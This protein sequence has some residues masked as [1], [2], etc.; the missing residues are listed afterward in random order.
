[1]EGKEKGRKER[2]KRILFFSPRKVA[3]LSPG[4]R[5]KSPRTPVFP[6]E[7]GKEEREKEEEMDGFR[8]RFLRGI[9]GKKDGRKDGKRMERMLFFSLS[10]GLF[11]LQKKEET[12]WYQGK[13]KGKKKEKKDEVLGL[14]DGIFR[15]R[16]EEGRTEEKKEEDLARWCLTRSSVYSFILFFVALS[17]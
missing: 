16:L 14:E 6:R 1:M 17:G 11:S 15:G 4:K 13:E 3:S 5:K 8:I 2:K 7:K 9:H 12:Q 10:G